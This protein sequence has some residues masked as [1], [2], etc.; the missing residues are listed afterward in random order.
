MAQES[1]RDDKNIKFRGATVKDIPSD[2]DLKQNLEHSLD[3]ISW[4]FNFAPVGI[5]F[6]SP[7][8]EI[9]DCNAAVEKF[10]DR[11]KQQII[12]HRIFDY[13]RAETSKS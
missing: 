10:L 5:A 6:V 1:F 2:R 8:G 13:I 12:N 3:E 7:E 11:S 4:L 9:K